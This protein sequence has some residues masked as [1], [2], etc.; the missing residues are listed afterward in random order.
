MEPLTFDR[1]VELAKEV[2]IEFGA[3]YVYPSSHRI[4]QNGTS[5]PSCVYVHEG[6]PSCLVGQILHKH[7]VPVEELAKHEFQ[8]AWTISEKLAGASFEA[9][10]FLDV[11][12]Y[13][14]DTGA[15]WG[16]AVNSAV[17]EVKTHL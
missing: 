7:G 12:Q 3:G 5:T 6:K 16:L 2:V 10:Y 8:G 14:Q 11:A 4:V 17:E 9:S 13:K 1:A 15:S